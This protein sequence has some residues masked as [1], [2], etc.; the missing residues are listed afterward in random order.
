MVQT[1][2]GGCQMASQANSERFLRA[3][4]LCVL[5]FALLGLSGCADW[6]F[7]R[8]SHLVDLADGIEWQL[9]RVEPRADLEAEE[10]AKVERVGLK[11]LRNARALAE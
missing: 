11:L 3:F 1:I 9:E 4:V 2:E 8:K 7:V 6:K 10:K 5:V